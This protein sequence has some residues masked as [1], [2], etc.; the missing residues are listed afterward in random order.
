MGDRLRGRELERL[1]ERAAGPRD[2][3]IGVEEHER[4]RHA[5]HDRLG[6]VACRRD[7][8]DARFERVDVF[9][10]IMAPSIWLSVVV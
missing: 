4:H 8:L 2:A 7:L 3:Q 9:S 1:K 5:V 6:M 10:V